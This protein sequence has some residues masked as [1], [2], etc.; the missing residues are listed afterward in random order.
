MDTREAP[1]YGIQATMTGP[2]R[3]PHQIAGHWTSGS[4]WAGQ[5]LIAPG[6]A[7]AGTNTINA[8]ASSCTGFGSA[9]VQR[10]V[11]VDTS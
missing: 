11:R 10:S 6:T 4:Q 5:Y 8:T 2:D 1:G 9:T 3:H 7:A